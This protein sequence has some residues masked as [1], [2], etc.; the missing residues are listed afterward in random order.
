MKE[1][2]T[3]TAGIALVFDY[4][5]RDPRARA[6]P[7]ARRHA[8]RHHARGGVGARLAGAPGR[9]LAPPGGRACGPRLCRGRGM[10]VLARGAPRSRRRARS[11]APD[12]WLRR[13]D[14]YAAVA[15]WLGFPQ[16]LQLRGRARPDPLP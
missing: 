11:L 7:D 14:R 12:D 9:A 8:A 2:F 1:T 16:R 4:G 13:G 15:G 6:A 5:V 10:G 3:I